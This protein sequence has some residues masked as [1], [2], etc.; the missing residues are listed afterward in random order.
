MILHSDD[1]RESEIDKEDGEE[2]NS[3]QSELELEI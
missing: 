1:E 2:N 3:E